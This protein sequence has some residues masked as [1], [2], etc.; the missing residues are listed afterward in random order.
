[1]VILYGQMSRCDCLSRDIALEDISLALDLLPRLRWRWERKDVGGGH[2]LIAKLAEFVLEGSLQT[3]TRPLQTPLLLPEPEWS[4]D[5]GVSPKH[6][7]SPSTPHSAMY[8]SAGS[9]MYGPHPQQGR[10]VPVPTGAQQQ[11]MVVNGGIRGQTRSDDSLE[12][13]PKNLFYPFYPEA[14]VA[15]PAAEPPD[16]QTLLAAA[17][18]QPNQD[19]YI[20]EDRQPQPTM[21]VNVVCSICFILVTCESHVLQPQQ[22]TPVYAISPQP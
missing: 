8:A 3:I 14:Q 19:T 16:Y 13:V 10:G 15:G 11:Q 20:Q 21:W 7:S 9:P 18:A 6:A 5:S 17:A 22:P 2:P 12:P 1:M 4:E